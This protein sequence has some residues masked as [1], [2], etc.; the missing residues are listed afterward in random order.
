MICRAETAE[1]Q[2]MK[3]GDFNA[4]PAK[5]D[6]G[7]EGESE[8]WNIFSSLDWNIFCSDGV[9]DWSADGQAAPAAPAAAA[10]ISAPTGGYQVR[11]ISKLLKYFLLVMEVKYF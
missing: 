11:N 3:T 5:E 10:A 8:D 9:Q 6:W 1:A 2:M 7:G 4:A